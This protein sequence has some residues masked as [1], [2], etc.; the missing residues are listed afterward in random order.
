M[1]EKINMWFVFS[2]YKNKV[3]KNCAKTITIADKIIQNPYFELSENSGRY[4]F[5][6]GNKDITKMPKITTNKP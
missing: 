5:K 3:A 4:T 1:K 6:R 2:R